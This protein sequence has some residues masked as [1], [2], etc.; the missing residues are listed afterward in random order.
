MSEQ[1]KEPS[2]FVS[3]VLLSEPVWDS[4]QFIKDLKDEWDLDFAT[5]EEDAGSTD[6]LVEK[7]GDG[8]LAV[9]L[10]PA[11]I[12]NGEAEDY[13]GANYMWSEAES[14]TK[15]HKAHILIAATGSDNDLIEKAKV[16]TKIIDACLKQKNAI[17]VY[18]DG[19]VYEP[20]FYH[21]VAQSLRDNELPIL[22]WVWFGIYYNGDVPGIYTYGLQKFGKEEI[23]V[24][25]NAPLGDIRD[26]VLEIVT[27]I[28]E[29]NVTLNDGE[30]IG[31]SE[32]QKLPITLSKGIALS[33]ESL[34]I[35]YPEE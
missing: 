21:M 16:T 12:P 17:A 24:Y 33:G 32:D 3:F 26:F 27:Y 2:H 5:E 34:K 4:R 6:T 10:I 23:E 22:D 35:A 9:A 15:S 8:F 31:F 30:T 1:N 19:A 20:Q 11:P 25:A 14:V 18:A 29:Y 7:F 13:A 28:L